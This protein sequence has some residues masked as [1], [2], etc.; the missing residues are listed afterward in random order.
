M[1]APRGSLTS[2]T[3]SCRTLVTAVAPAKR[4]ID[5]TARGRRL[6]M[7]FPEPKEECA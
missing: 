2:A 3:A 4:D 5:A 6:T 1:E 7:D